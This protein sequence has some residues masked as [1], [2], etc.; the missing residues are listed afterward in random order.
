MS[1]R[2][3]RMSPFCWQARDATDLV[4]EQFSGRER[5]T[6]VAIYQS[7]TDLASRHWRA[8]GRNGFQSSRKEVADYAGVS[9]R[10]VDAYCDRFVELG[11][12]RVNPGNGYSNAWTL[13]ASGGCAAPDTPQTGDA[14][15]Q[16]QGVRSPSTTQVRSPSTTPY[17]QEEQPRREEPRPPDVGDPAEQIG[18]S[19]DQFVGMRFP[20][21]VEKKR[22]KPDEAATAGTV[23]AFFNETAGTHYRSK[24]HLEKIIRR[25]REHPDVLLDQHIELVGRVLNGHKWWEGRADPRIIYGNDAQFERALNDDG[26]PPADRRNGRSTQFERTMEIAD[27]LIAGEFGT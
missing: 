16:H 18:L 13:I 24:E 17:T 10:T 4:R 20:V 7:L 15:R 27:R 26:S 12:L 1:V 11:L 23:L 3:E 14:Q 6:A 19:G 5:T 25:M 22:V 2:D 21:K 9:L 8:G